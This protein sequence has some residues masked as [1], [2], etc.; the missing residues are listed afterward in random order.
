MQE[1]L[2]WTLNAIRNDDMVSSLIEERKFDWIPLV[3][4][5]I[6]FIMEGKTIILITDVQ[7]E[8]F[9]RYII[10]SIN[11]IHL[12]RPIIPIANL[13][14]IY[15]HLDII[16]NSEKIDLL[17][18]MLSNSYKDNYFFWYIGK[19]SDKRVDIAKR[20]KGDFIWI[21]DEEL[22]NSFPLKSDDSNLDIQLIQLYK[23]FNM[24][25]NA[26]LFCEISLDR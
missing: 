19:G 3:A 7:R 16:T 14:D 21:F 5:A 11:N 15:P 1:L 13:S 4:N 10:T 8:W 23:L 17:N 24:T 2:K 25:L 12:D 9:G 22:S 6:S 26:V 20:E 18:D